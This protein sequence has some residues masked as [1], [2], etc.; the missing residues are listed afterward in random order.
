M[1]SCVASKPLHLLQA[2]LR[3]KY[4]VCLPENNTTDFLD[5][6]L[7]TIVV[8]D[9]TLEIYLPVNE[10]L[11]WGTQL[12]VKGK[13]YVLLDEN[14][15]GR[16][17]SDVFPDPY[18]RGY[19]GAWITIN[20]PSCVVAPTLSVP[21]VSNRLWPKFEER[22]VHY[23]G[24]DE[25]LNSGFRTLYNAAIAY[26]KLV[27]DKE[28]REEVERE[29]L[30]LFKTPGDVLQ[31]FHEGRQLRSVAEG[32]KNSLNYF[33]E[34]AAKVLDGVGNEQTV[35]ELTEQTY[36]ETQTAIKDLK[37]KF[38]IL[39]ETLTKEAKDNPMAALK[40]TALTSL[41]ME[42]ETQA[43]RSDVF[44]LQD[45]YLHL[46]GKSGSFEGFVAE[47]L[48]D[49]CNVPDLNDTALQQALKR[50]R[51]TLLLKQ[52]P[53]AKKFLEEVARFL[54]AKSSLDEFQRLHAEETSI[55]NKIL[56]E[57]L[58]KGIDR[59]VSAFRDY[60]R[61]IEKQPPGKRQHILVQGKSL[62]D[63][64]MRFIE[65]DGGVAAKS[66]PLDMAGAKLIEIVKKEVSLYAVPDLTEVVR[67]CNDFLGYLTEPDQSFNLW[68]KLPFKE[69]GTLYPHVTIMTCDENAIAA[70][71]ARRMYGVDVLFP[72]EPHWFNNHNIS[73]DWPEAVAR[74]IT[75]LWN[76]K[77][78]H[79]FLKWKELLISSPAPMRPKER[80]ENMGRDL[81]IFL[82]NAV[83]H[84]NGAKRK[85][86]LGT[87]YIQA[88]KTVL[89]AEKDV[90]EGTDFDRWCRAVHTQAFNSSMDCSPRLTGLLTH[91]NF[92]EAVRDLNVSPELTCE[93]GHGVNLHALW[94]ALETSA[95]R[96]TTQT[97]RETY[98]LRWLVMSD[99]PPFLTWV[100]PCIVFAF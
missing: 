41:V 37:T 62:E 5:L 100:G 42:T 17:F 45:S 23:Y 81:A 82:K 1:T 77:V 61:Y 96:M 10:P 48:V 44:I 74:N 93:K 98:P 79:A 92:P 8:L 78:M 63:Y 55:R 64:I 83:A 59:K 38:E 4:M 36:S 90:N 47:D 26:A 3:E 22:L 67:Y 86:T 12:V 68:I 25:H 72:I 46:R 84:D 2:E 60:I 91:K 80:L 24:D 15:E 18:F 66:K 14:V 21:E 43:Q 40:K 88:T 34:T 20:C 57:V 58:G 52:D 99:L 6:G 19:V 16:R 7:V 51:K 31:D 56:S 65:F 29:Q 53:S 35:V 69:S 73:S 11:W 30:T 70:K 49:D 13:S 71:D 95:K 75:N 9:E 97:W 50:R 87:L 54:P 94:T 76:Q 28:D 32:I 33:P 89:S 27:Q 39:S 85:E